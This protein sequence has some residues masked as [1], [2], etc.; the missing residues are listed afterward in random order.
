[1]LRKRK[2]LNIGGANL[3]YYLVGLVT[4]DG[5]L[6]PDG[7]HVDITSSDYEFLQNIVNLF[8][9]SNKIGIK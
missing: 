4:S 7:R 2:N 5:N 8:G 6:S 3:W 1:M 9:L